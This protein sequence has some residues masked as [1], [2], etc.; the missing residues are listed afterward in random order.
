[1]GFFSK[2][3]KE[4]VLLFDIGNG[5]IGV[6][7]AEISD[8]KNILNKAK[9]VEVYRETI[10]FQEHLRFDHFTKTVAKS[11]ENAAKRV[12]AELKY[13]IEKAYLILA[14]PWYASQTR[15]VNLRKSESFTFTEELFAEMIKKESDDFKNEH[16]KG[17]F[18][19]AAKEDNLVLIEQ[20]VVQLKCNGYEIEDPFDKKVKTI[21]M[22]LYL[23]VA[24]Q[25]VLEAFVSAI[26]NVFPK[27][28][29]VFG[30]FPLA[31]FFAARELYP[32]FDDALLVDVSGEVTDIAFVLNGAL[33]EITSFPLGR[34]TIFRRL[35]S[36]LHRPAEEIISL[37]STFFTGKTNKEMS[38]KIEKAFAEIAD[39]WVVSFEKA[40]EKLAD[41][42]YLPDQVFLT[43]DDD[44][45]KWLVEGI[46]KE[47]FSQ[48]VMTHTPFSVVDTNTL[49]NAR[50]KHIFEKGE[51]DVF[52]GIGAFYII[53][54]TNK[55][56]RSEAF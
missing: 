22:P 16:I 9:L 25:V 54:N 6:A 20:H 18:K 40:L 32:K 38:I 41:T 8:N 17:R 49:F 4:F 19:K 13:P 43:A 28:D 36:S 30:T 46:K 1:M 27:I 44:I 39:S 23:S 3:D 50:G 15:V 7:V 10:P 35:S 55:N 26:K 37:L 42:F 31:Y 45:K 48:Y 53:H 5:S 56:F 47:S 34:N 14:S 33:L 51:V 12:Q 29:I 24:P 52:L 21:E 11:I 2:N